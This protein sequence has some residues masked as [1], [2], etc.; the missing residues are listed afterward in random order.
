[1]DDCCWKQ[2]ENIR[3]T[4]GASQSYDSTEP[5]CLPEISELRKVEGLQDYICTAHHSGKYV[6]I[7]R[8]GAEVVLCEV[9][10]FILPRDKYKNVGGE[11]WGSCGGREGHCSWCGT[12]GLCCRRGWASNGC[13]GQWGGDTYH[14]CVKGATVSINVN[15]EEK[16]CHGHL[17]PLPTTI[18]TP[19]TMPTT[20][21]IEEEEGLYFHYVR[22]T[23]C[24]LSCEL[25]QTAQRQ[26]AKLHQKQTGNDTH[27]M[28]N[29]NLTMTDFIQG[30]I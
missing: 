29:A 28:H 24:F 16:G 13:N 11:C 10:V 8:A 30:L 7:S 20:T 25:S 23:Y 14:M 19:T 27:I 15:E 2:G 21:M 3:I 17:L 12:E 4:V 1:M 9:K 5:L 18:A 26:K 6:K 22:V